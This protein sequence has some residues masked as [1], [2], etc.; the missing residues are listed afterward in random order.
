MKVFWWQ[1]GLHLEPASE[2]ESVALEGLV[3]LLGG[4]Q[5]DHR[6]LAGP[7]GAVETDNQQ[8][9]VR[10]HELPEVIAQKQRA[11]VVVPKNPL[12]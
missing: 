10:V 8:P 6:I 12:G 2:D 1:G 4:V 11:S 3:K 5:I 7:V 9:V